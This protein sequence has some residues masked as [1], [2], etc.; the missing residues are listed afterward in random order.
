MQTLKPDGKDTALFD[1]IGPCLERFEA[2]TTTL[3]NVD[4]PQHLI[5]LTDGGDNFSPTSAVLA[6]ANQLKLTS[7]KLHVS[8]HIVLVGDRNRRGSR[9]LSDAL[10]YQFHHFNGGNASEFSQSLLQRLSIENDA[11]R[12]STVTNQE[13]TNFLLTR[14]PSVPNTVERV[15]KRRELA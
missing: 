5:I 2:L 11:A 6:H 4:V 14:L 13:Q 8:G 1:A 10:G 12:A 9:M 15:Q 3:G 7:K